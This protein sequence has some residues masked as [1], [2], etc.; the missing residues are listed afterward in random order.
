MEGL[1]DYTYELTEELRNLGKSYE[2]AEWAI[3]QVHVPHYQR[4]LFADELAE[5]IVTN[6]TT[7]HLI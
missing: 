7:L 3:D 6:E 4:R 2:W 5:L 1:E